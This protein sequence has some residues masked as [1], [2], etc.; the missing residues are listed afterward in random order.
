MKKLY[1]LGAGGFAREVAWLVTRINEKKPEWDLQG[2]VSNE[3][4]GKIIYKNYKVVG[5]DD[6][7]LGLDYEFWIVCAVGS[8]NIRAK[9]IQRYYSNSNIHFATLIDP[10]VSISSDCSIGEGSVICAGNIITVN[11][12]IGRHVIVNLNCTVGH[13]SILNDFVTINPGVNVSGKVD[14]GSKSEIGTGAKIIQGKTIAPNI[15]VGAGGI[16]VRNLIEKGTYVG[17]PVKKIK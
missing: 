3:S 16:V 7:L 9:I 2:F 1:I 14:I 6:F 5:N 8:S 17:V 4:V 10:T 15:I 12:S 11:V 13:D